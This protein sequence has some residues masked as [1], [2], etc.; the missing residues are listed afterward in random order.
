MEL[1][2]MVLPTIIG[3]L[4]IGVILLAVLTIIRRANQKRCPYCAETV[5]KMA[6]VCKHCGKDI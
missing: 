4:V 6:K 3:S 2:F 5:Q 1:F